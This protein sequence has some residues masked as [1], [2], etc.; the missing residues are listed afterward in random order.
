MEKADVV[1]G[2]EKAKPARV[3]MMDNQLDG[4]RNGACLDLRARVALDMLTHSPAIAGMAEKA[5]PEEIALYCL[6]AATYLLDLATERGMVEEFTEEIG[7]RLE[8]HVTRQAED[9]V[10]SAK[11]SQRV[12]EKATRIHRAVAGAL[13]Q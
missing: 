2:L 9:Q 7:K 12:Q 5:G 8:A 11:E 3:R 1:A 13:N 10:F 6:D 4:F